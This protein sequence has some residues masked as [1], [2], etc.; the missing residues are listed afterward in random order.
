MYQYKLYNLQQFAIMPASEIEIWY[1]ALEPL[2]NGLMMA[3]RSESYAKKEVRKN[4]LDFSSFLLY[5]TI[6]A[7]G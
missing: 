1:L 7:G 2:C 3:E 5:L 6:L 4:T